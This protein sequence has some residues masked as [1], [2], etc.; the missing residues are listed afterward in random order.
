MFQTLY[1]EFGFS[2]LQMKALCQM[3]HYKD[4]LYQILDWSNPK[5][6]VGKD[7]TGRFEKK[8]K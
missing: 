8:D 1:S 3:S 5:C 7:E 2:N 6:P 4:L